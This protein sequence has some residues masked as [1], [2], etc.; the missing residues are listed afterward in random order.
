MFLALYKSQ[1][2]RNRG[3]RGCTRTP[4]LFDRGCSRGCALGGAN[5]KKSAL[6]MSF[7]VKSKAYF[8]SPVEDDFFENKVKEVFIINK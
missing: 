4:C 3:C 5:E 2:R 1:G 6:F 8:V 7:L